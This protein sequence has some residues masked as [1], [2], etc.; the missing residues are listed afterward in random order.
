M[1]A[2][3]VTSVVPRDS[4]LWDLAGQVVVSRIGSAPPDT[5]ARLRPFFIAMARYTLALSCG[6]AGD[7]ERNL[8]AK[9][10]PK[11]RA[12]FDAFLR[13]ENPAS[14]PALEIDALKQ[15]LL[16]AGPTF[17]A[18]PRL[19]DEGDRPPTPAAGGLTTVPIEE[20]AMHESAARWLIE[21][22]WAAEGVGMIGAH[23]KSKKT[24]LALEMAVS[25]ASGTPCLGRFA[26]TDPGPVLAI[27]AEDPEAEVRERLRLLGASRGCDL[28]DLPIHYVREA[29]VL[30]DSERDTERL[31][32]TVERLRPKLLILDPFVRLH[33]GDEDDAGHVARVLGYLRGLQRE[34]HVA[35]AMV[36]HYKKQVS[37]RGP[38]GLGLRGSG[39][40][41]AWGDSNL[42]IRGSEGEGLTLRAEHR[43]APSTGPWRLEV[44]EP[45]AL[46]A[47]VLLDD[48][49]SVD[50]DDSAR[51]RILALLRSAEGPMTVTEIRRQARV[52]HSTVSSLLA[53]MVAAGTLI[54]D[55]E[56]Y[57]VAE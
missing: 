44:T 23:P 49:V 45:F 40:F 51:D 8:A 31:T 17:A 13:A 43:S 3:S 47:V 36:H 38:D 26:V 55:G 25:V 54:R 41:F 16:F 9:H 10:W 6:E 18:W 42:Y 57:A 56:G 7:D 35:V 19:D 1:Q 2:A 14:G 4:F 11:A 24:W 52:R 27:V 28:H 29:R 53:E 12:A 32:R 15:A 50:I 34:F 46:R 20:L 33:A 22:L 39:D 21:S 5:K 37:R 48:E 30:L